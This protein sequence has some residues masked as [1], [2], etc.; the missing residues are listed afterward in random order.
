ML[1]SGT[2]FHPA[3]DTGQLIDGVIGKTPSH[4]RLPLGLLGNSITVAAARHPITK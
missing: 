1:F 2:F 3:A 4:T